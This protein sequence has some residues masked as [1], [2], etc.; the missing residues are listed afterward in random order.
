MQNPS[1][2]EQKSINNLWKIDPKSRKSDFERSWRFQGKGPGL[3]E[4]FL[5]DFGRQHGANLGPSWS[6]FGV[7]IDI[8]LHKKCSY[9]WTDFVASWGLFLVQ[10]WVQNG[11]KIRA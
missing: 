7:N 2:I 10:I 11:V 4:R 1:K 5:I 6:Q 3:Q 9:F 8:Q